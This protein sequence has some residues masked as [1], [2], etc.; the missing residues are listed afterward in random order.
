[1]KKTFTKI[2]SMTLSIAVMFAF[3]CFPTGCT[4]P[5]SVDP[6]TVCVVRGVHDLFPDVSLP[7][8]MV[9]NYIE[10]VFS[11]GTDSRAVDIIV[12]GKPFKTESSTASLLR[13][14]RVLPKTAKAVILLIP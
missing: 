2:W 4:P 8:D 3:L 10:D 7:N 11:S 14:S 1:M 12:D 9:C 13:R 6:V 5:T